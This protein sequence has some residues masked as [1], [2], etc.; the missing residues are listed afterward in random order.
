MKEFGSL[1]LCV[2]FALAVS[3]CATLSDAQVAG[4][5][6]RSAANSNEFVPID[7]LPFETISY[8]RADGTRVTDA[9]WAAI[10]TNIIRTLLPNQE[11]VMVTRK[12]S[13]DGRLSYLTGSITGEAGTYEVLQDYVQYR[14]EDIKNQS[15][16]PIGVGRV[17]LG[18][19]IKAYV[20][21]R[22]SGIDLGSL[23]ALGVAAKQG[24]LNGKLS[25]AVMGLY[26]ADITTLFPTPSDINETSIQKALEAM[27]AIKSKI[28]DN[29]TSLTPQIVA[30]KVTNPKAL[31]VGLSQRLQTGALEML[32]AP[33][34]TASSH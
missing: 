27:A 19:R 32:F 14:I 34:R 6:Y 9:A 17:G 16:A 12:V 10:P 3:G 11:A 7:P 26:S 28:G 33:E 4:I 18:L 2:A 15:G 25:V 20:E 31:D 22:K 1:V 13:T 29:A 30:I 21:T 8:V 5:Q 23:I 24:Y